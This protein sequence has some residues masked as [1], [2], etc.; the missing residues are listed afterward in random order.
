MEQLSG[1]II[2][3]QDSVTSTVSALTISPVKEASMAKKSLPEVLTIQQ[4][5]PRSRKG[6]V[7][8]GESARKYRTAEYATYL[9]AKARCAN[10]NNAAFRYYGGRGIEFRFVSY[11]EF[12]AHVGR[13][14]AP[15]Y[16]LD[17]INNNG[18]YEPGNVRWVTMKEQSDNRR[19]TRWITFKG[20]RL[21]AADWAR[22]LGVGV[23]TIQARKRAGWCDDCTV[24]LSINPKGNSKRRHSCTHNEK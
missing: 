23:C 12:L 10:P 20:E 2:T 1:K 15:Q 16:S 18:H 4:I 7:T 24:T 5:A 21:C 3:S 11:I 8:H 22:R 19:T 9:E 17:R 13:K 14:P 6:G